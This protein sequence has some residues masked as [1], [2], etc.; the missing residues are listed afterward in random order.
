MKFSDICW[1]R[2]TEVEI[3][4]LPSAAEQALAGADGGPCEIEGHLRYFHKPV[5]VTKQCEKCKTMKV[6]RI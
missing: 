1:H 3:E 2:W 4:V 6:Q 5:I